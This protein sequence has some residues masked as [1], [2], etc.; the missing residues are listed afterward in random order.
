MQFI[1]NWA[2]SYNKKKQLQRVF[3]GYFAGD[4]DRGF[5]ALVVFMLLWI[6]A[7][8]WIS[9]FLTE[10]ADADAIAA[11]RIL[12]LIWSDGSIPSLFCALRLFKYFDTHLIIP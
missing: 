12:D 10:C 5:D 4:F 8:D 2:N 3:D 6:S 9:G 11:S 7:V 1:S